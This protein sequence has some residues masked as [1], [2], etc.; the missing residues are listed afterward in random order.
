[1]SLNKEACLKA[2]EVFSEDLIFVANAN[3]EIVESSHDTNEHLPGI[4]T[5]SIS[6]LICNAVLS[7]SKSGKER[8]VFLS[9]FNQAKDMLEIL[10]K[11][12]GG[13]STHSCP[14]CDSSME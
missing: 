10:I 5:S 1:M 6:T 14:K 2:I 13:E 12:N 9:L 7:M 3:I 4:V 11:H 8:D